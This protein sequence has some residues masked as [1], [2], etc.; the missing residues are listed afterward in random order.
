ME[1]YLD[2][3]L[4]P[5]ER[6]RDLLGR[7][8]LREKVGQL[9][10]RLY[11]FAIYERSGEQIVFNDEFRAEV[12]RY[13][14]MG[15]LY[16]LYRA[17][18]WS[19]R[20]FASGL[21]GELSP[22][23]RNAVQRY[24]MEHSRFG[25]PVLMA[26]ECPHGHQALDGCL[27]P[28]NLAA[29]AAFDP[30]LLAEAAAVCGRQLREMG[31]DLALVSC[32]DVL[33]D[34]RW[35]RSEECFGE[36]PLLCSRLT[37]A[38][39]GALRGEGVDV[40]A[41]HLCAQ[42]ETT[43][44][45]NAS[46]ARIGPRELREIHLP[47]AEAAVRAGAAGMMAAYNE[48]DGIYCHANRRLLTDYLRGELGFGGIVMSDGVALDQLDAV[49]GSRL[50]S[51]ALGMNAGVDMGLWDT[52]FSLLE[53][54]VERGLVSEK[55]IDEAA[56]RV[57][58]LKFRRGLF[59]EPFVAEGAHWQAYASPESFPQPERLAEQ[60]PVLLK[61]SGNLLPLTGGGRRILLTGP[62]SDNIYAQL[63]DYTPPQR[64]GSG[65]TIHQAMERLA[66]ERGDAMS[67]MPGCPMFGAHSDGALALAESAARESDLVVVVLG[68]SSSRFSGGEFDANGALLAQERATMDCGEGVD[69]CELRLP[70]AQMEL[71]RAMRRT[72]R[73]LVTV[74]IAGRPYAM[75]EI[76]RLSDAIIYAFY[77]GP[78]GGKAIAGLIYG[79][80][81]PAG[82][83]PA[84]LPD[85]VGQLP[86][87]YN[88][89]DSYAAM[90]YYDSPQSAPRWH[91]GA[92]LSYTS[93]S[94]REKKGP[95][96]ALE[97]ENPGENGVEIGVEAVNTG[98]RGGYAVPQ[99][100]I[101]RTQGIATSRA[102]QL[103]DFK[104]LFIPAGERGEFTLR[105]A[106]ESLR[107]WDGER[108][109]TPPGRIEWFVCDGGETL[110]SGEFTLS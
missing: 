32:L 73:P 76:E 52:A 45:V 99:L 59:E 25:I 79:E 96:G 110:L 105:I 23:A 80:I 87:Y 92:G 2:K 34:P 66:G 41:K 69:A 72:G 35:G 51:G 58:E 86:V 65:S 18:P 37:E 16:G 21:D 50:L 15:A 85:T 30:R 104:K 64:P 38:V 27:L 33:R 78:M 49:T 62:A 56:G 40:V 107:Q 90:R 53:E 89:K 101:H 108:W 14:G 68:G 46:A 94:W 82:R 84:S 6:A 19:A 43:G 26:T 3:S 24:V 88:Y 4:P 31:V 74:L 55:R 57:L 10:Q 5:A 7:M 81:E 77:P 102:R 9:N 12:K 70:G 17:D 91:F 63:G 95:H 103:C 83:L 109:V 8:S 98:G 20:D 61:N 36:D 54:A 11:G 44:G 42:G 1:A 75:E 106:P 28:V 22:R 93:F 100:Y 48:I 97:G 39:I 29:A 13:S 60:T 67:Y 71:L 47:P